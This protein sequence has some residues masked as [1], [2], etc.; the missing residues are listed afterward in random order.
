MSLHSG[1]AV[2]TEAAD[3][4][5]NAADTGRPISPCDISSAVPTSAS[6][7]PS[8]RSSCGDDVPRA[9]RWWDARSD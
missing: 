3:L 6:P 4:L 7:T 5:T 2:V 9:A 1:A 8:S